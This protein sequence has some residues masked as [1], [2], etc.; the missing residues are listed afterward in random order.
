MGYVVRASTISLK[1]FHGYAHVFKC[2]QPHN[3]RWR[4]YCDVA[5]VETLDEARHELEKWRGKGFKLEVR[6]V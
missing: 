2:R 5:F 6:E 3:R 1:L 4:Y